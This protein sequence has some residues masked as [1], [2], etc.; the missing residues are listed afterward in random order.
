MILA[1]HCLKA[2]SNLFV[3]EWVCGA[4]LGGGTLSTEQ[5]LSAVLGRP[6][7]L[8]GELA[9]ACLLDPVADNVQMN[10]DSKVI[11][12]TADLQAQLCWVAVQGRR[13][14]CRR[15]CSGP[16]IALI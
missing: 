4:A 10:N 12:F 14:L 5:Y 11:R 8:V 15:I 6:C 13:C 1:T 9:H 2:L 7:G 3:T 16:T